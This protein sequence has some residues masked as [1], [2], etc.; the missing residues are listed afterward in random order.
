VTVV[1]PKIEPGNTAEER[2]IAAAIRN[3][4]PAHL[5]CWVVWLEPEKMKEAR[6][7]YHTWLAATR[8]ARRARF[9]MKE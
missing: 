6:I 9:G 2:R 7:A 1:L 5:V 8:R 4:L 3:A